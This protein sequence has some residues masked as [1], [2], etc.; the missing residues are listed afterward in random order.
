MQVCAF[1]EFLYKK[2]MKILPKFL[3]CFFP[4][5]LHHGPILCYNFHSELW[6]CQLQ[7]YGKQ[8][9]HRKGIES[10]HE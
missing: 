1:F 3:I 6:C 4:E 7:Q 9:A 2:K 8:A 5:K 10:I